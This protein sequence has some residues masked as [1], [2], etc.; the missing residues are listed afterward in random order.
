MKVEEGY[1][2]YG[3]KR[4]LVEKNGK[5]DVVTRKSGADCGERSFRNYNY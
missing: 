1:I 2:K 4:M 3:T 5:G